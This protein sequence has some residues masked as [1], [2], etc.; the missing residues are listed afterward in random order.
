MVNT[1]TVFM[2]ASQLVKQTALT[3][4]CFV[5]LLH[6]IDSFTDQHTVKDHDA[7]L[8]QHLV[9]NISATSGISSQ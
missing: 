3:G 4:A 8:S 2:Y 9:K 7:F 5:Y 6:D 1:P